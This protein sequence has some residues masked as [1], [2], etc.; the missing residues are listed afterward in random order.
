MGSAGVKKSPRLPHVPKHSWVRLWSLVPHVRGSP[1]LT[2]YGHCVRMGQGFG[3]FLGLCEKGLLSFVI[4]PWG[5]SFPPQV[6][7]F[8]VLLLLDP[9]KK[10]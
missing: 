7:F 4:I 6:E 9:E 8:L 3:G 10:G 1:I 2:G 5:R